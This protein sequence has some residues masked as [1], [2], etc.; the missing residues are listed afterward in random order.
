MGKFLLGNLENEDPKEE[1]EI[2]YNPTVQGD[3]DAD[4]PAALIP[5][6]GYTVI[7][8][9]LNDT[10]LIR[11]RSFSVALFLRHDVLILSRCRLSCVFS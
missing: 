6:C 11:S 5:S 1:R 4:L 3:P 10:L 9:K 2:M 8:S 7:C